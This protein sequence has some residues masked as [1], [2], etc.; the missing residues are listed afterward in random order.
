MK[1]LNLAIWMLVVVLGV[2]FTGCIEDDFTTSSSDL[3]EFSTD[4]L[5]FDTVLT[6]VGTPTKQFVVYN[7][8]KKMINISSIK[9]SGESSGRFYLNVDGVTGEEFHDVEIRGN[10]SIFVFVEAFIDPSDDDNPILF[11]D[12]ID[13]TTNG[14]TQQVVITAWG[15]N[16]DRLYSHCVTEDTHFTAARPYVIFDTLRVAEGATLTLDAGARLYF[17]DKA[18][19]VVDGTLL[20]NGTMEKPIDLRGDRLDKVVGDIGYDIMSGQWDGV[21][22]T[23][24]SY[25]N[26]LRH[27][28]MRG[29]S[30]GVIAD[31]ASM[32]Q[33]KLLI[34]N[35]VLHNSA[36]SVLTASHVWVDAL[37]SELSEAHFA[38]ASLTGGKY[39]FVNCT[40]A[41][42]YLFSII[43]EPILSLYYLLPDHSDGKTPL[44]TA[45]FDNCIFYGNASGI[46]EG[47]LTGS[48]VLLRNCLL[49]AGGEDD[50]NFIE[51][52]W[53]GDPKFYTIREEYIFDYRLHN[54]SQAIGK[55]NPAL[56]PASIAADRYGVKRL[57]PD[58]T[59]D[60]GAYTWVEEVEE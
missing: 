29:T 51:C 14:V 21:R 2:A 19:M 16:V 42:Y 17:H 34:E 58:G 24:S 9:L 60:I 32:E 4:T 44:M 3:P 25:G 23:Q 1:R 52:V 20:A 11:E 31:S 39:N 27:T 7:R 50:D 5:A 28:Y 53:E 47:D 18:A 56:C 12:K 15:Q 8:H 33:R 55:G 37:G 35:S 30:T 45:N 41:N 57:H 13:F 40:L 26:V 49:G 54:E 43:E 46:N 38:V 6:D 36:G 22:F 59:I 10:D 48:A